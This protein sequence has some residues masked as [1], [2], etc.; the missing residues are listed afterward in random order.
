MSAS[1]GY[2][3]GTRH[4][5]Y[6]AEELFRSLERARSGGRFRLWH[7]G[8]ALKP[9]EPRLSGSALTLLRLAWRDRRR[10]LQGL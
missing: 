4:I 3:A 9:L 7:Y 6:A 2:G 1:D 5:D 10:L 8:L